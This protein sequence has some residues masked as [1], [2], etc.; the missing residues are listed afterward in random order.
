[1]RSTQ[2]LRSKL[3]ERVAPL[4]DQVRRS[5][6]VKSLAR[7]TLGALDRLSGIADQALGKRGL[8]GGKLR[9]RFGKIRTGLEDLSKGAPPRRARRGARPEPGAMPEGEPKP[10]KPDSMPEVIRSTSGGK[11]V[12]G[13]VAQRA[14]K[15]A[16][17]QKRVKKG[18]KKH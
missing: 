3:S 11:R 4:R 8:S 14:V 12:S 2:A 18:Q 13:E 1:M 9:A 5:D 6:A 10:E 7:R 16:T 15:R 17:T